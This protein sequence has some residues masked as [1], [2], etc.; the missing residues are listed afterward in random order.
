MSNSSDLIRRN[1]KLV[2]FCRESLGLV[3]GFQLG[4]VYTGQW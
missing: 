1:V 2:D 4:L 3:L